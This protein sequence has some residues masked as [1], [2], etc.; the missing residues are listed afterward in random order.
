MERIK[1]KNKIKSALMTEDCCHLI[2]NDE[3]NNVHIWDLNT[4]QQ[5]WELKDPEKIEQVFNSSNYYNI[6]FYKKKDSLYCGYDISKKK[7]K[8]E[9]KCEGIITDT[10][11]DEKNG[12]I[13]IMYTLKNGYKIKKF[14]IY[15]NLDDSNDK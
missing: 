12:F 13:Y 1:S 5:L 14:D 11:I 2:T 15:V 4:K 6:L 9:Y 7:E 8:F 3:E 10:K